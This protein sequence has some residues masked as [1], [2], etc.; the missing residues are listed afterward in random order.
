MLNLLIMSSNDSQL[1]HV[2]RSQSIDPIHH[3]ASFQTKRW[4][5]AISAGFQIAPNVLLRA[6]RHLGLDTGDVVILLNLAMHWWAPNVLPYPSPTIIANRM[7]LS[8]RTIERRLE[9]LQ[10]RGFL[11]RLP[12]E[13]GERRRYDLSGMV[14]KLE[15][16][17]AV[18]L[19][20]R[21]YS[22]R[23]AASESRFGGAPE[24]FL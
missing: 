10:K 23:R 8:K 18:G 15:S 7:G 17:A 21:E 9:S 5:S 12:A 3:G 6:Q 14:E 19:A 24:R 2:P 22:K 1:V 20:H 13:D 16:A 11:K 4:G